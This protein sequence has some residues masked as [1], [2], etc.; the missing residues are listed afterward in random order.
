MKI[1]PW[2]L[3]GERQTSSSNYRRWQAKQ[4][5]SL[6]LFKE[7]F[8]EINKKFAPQGPKTEAE[9]GGGA[10][11]PTH[12]AA[13]GWVQ[14][15]GRA[16]VHAGE[17]ILNRSQQMAMAGGMARN[18]SI[19]EIVVNASPGMDENMLAM[20]VRRQIVAALEEAA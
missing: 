15:S 12:F 2:R 10:A 7:W 5:A 3:N 20:A 14:R 9:A 4:G 16:T 17:L 13:G 1:G 11:F 8:D 19:G 18:V 6:K